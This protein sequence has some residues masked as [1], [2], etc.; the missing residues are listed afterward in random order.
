MVRHILQLVRRRQKFRATAQ[1]SFSPE[2]IKPRHTKK[3]YFNLLSSNDVVVPAGV[4]DNEVE[5]EGPEVAMN[6]IYLA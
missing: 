6:K 2:Y 1:T 5:V 3:I 4:V